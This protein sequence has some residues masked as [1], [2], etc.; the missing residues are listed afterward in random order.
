MS[1]IYITGHKNPDMDS[2]CA[3]LGYAVLKNLIDPG[4]TYV[5]VRC[6]HMGE[7]T[8]KMLS[9]L[10]IQAPKY[11]R[12]VYP[13]VSDVM[14]SPVLKV[15]ADES[16]RAYA[17]LYSDSNPSSIPVFEGEKFLGLI[18]IDDVVAWAMSGLAENG[19]INELPRIR[20][21]MRPHDT[22]LDAG[23][24]FEEAK[25]IL[26]RDNVRGLP[27][28]NGESFAGYVTRRCFLNPPR[29]S[30]ILIDHNEPAQSI[31]GIETANIIEIIDHHR[32]N[33]L[34][35]DLPLFIDAEPLGSTC[36]IVYQLF[37]RN[38]IRPSRDTAKVLLTG[39]VADTL[40]LK[41]PTTTPIDVES[42]R[43]LAAMCG[44]EVESYGRNMFSNIEDLQSRNP[45]EAITSDFKAYDECGVKFG[46]GQCETTSLQT[47]DE[48]VNE[49][50]S[51]LEDVRQK[52]GYNW[53]LLMVTDVIKEQS[54]LLSTSFRAERHLPYARMGTGTYDM[55][56]VMSRKKQLLPE[57]IHAVSVL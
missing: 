41:S 11:M 3:A 34:K 50:L 22:V 24:L 26:S 36:T 12:D 29:Y 43:A 10:E 31:K 30:V 32:L 16:L 14:L 25:A 42:A 48:Y 40:I 28:F 23:D 39:I 21:V 20:D 7:G 51:A 47:L 56:G 33:A 57:L 54:V 35:T 49:Y 18:S 44:V 37:L 8:K 52:E 9:A 15:D 27:V 38:G 55:P 4:N 13:K 46:V 45:V 17:G 19:M 2:I 1:T 53:A 6:S 5:P